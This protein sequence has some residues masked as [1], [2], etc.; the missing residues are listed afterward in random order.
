MAV[1]FEGVVVA[2]EGFVVSGVLCLVVVSEVVLASEGV[3]VSGVLCLVDLQK[4]LDSLGK[5]ESQ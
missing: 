2:F 4:Q 3:V 1:A 5:R